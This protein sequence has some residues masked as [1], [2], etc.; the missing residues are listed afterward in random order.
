MAN[1]GRTVAAHLVPWVPPGSFCL[2][3]KEIAQGRMLLHLSD[4]DGELGSLWQVAGF[5]ALTHCVWRPQR[6]P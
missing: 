6:L 1:A 2:Q 4:V 3:N 5:G